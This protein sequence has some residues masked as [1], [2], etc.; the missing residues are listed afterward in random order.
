[1]T[2]GH[3]AKGLITEIIVSFHDDG[4]IDHG[5][6]G[7]LID[8]QLE[9]GAAGFFV[10][11]L[12][13]E[14]YSLTFEE[15]VSV[16]RTVADRCKGYDVRIMACIFVTTVAEG[17]KLMDLHEGIGHDC[18]CFTAPPLFEFTDEAL[19]RFTSDLMQYTDLPCYIYNCREMA[20]LYS[21]DLLH[22]I[23]KANV[24]FQGYKDATRDTVHL[25]QCMMRLDPE[26]YD[27]LCGCDGS[28]VAH[29]LIGGCGTVSFMG[30]PFPKETRA[31]CDLVLEGRH[32]EAMEAQYRLLRIRNVLKLAPNSAAY[33]YAQRFTG[34]PLARNTRMPAEMISVDEDVKRQIDALMQELGYSSKRR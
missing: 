19:F 25:L 11:G 22:R 20:T 7:D 33:M 15:R 8:F 17:K 24:N 5:T 6:T 23:A 18:F 21:P 2:E 12:G 30:V 31:I 28:L 13:D 4:S 16:L 29:M 14:V 27:F 10:N 1:M 3:F 32:A 26:R 34:G 9:Q